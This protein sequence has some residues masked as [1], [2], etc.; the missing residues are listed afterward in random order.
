M[1]GWPA[2][3]AFQNWTPSGA[4]LA[5]WRH[6]LAPPID[7][8]GVLR[9]EPG[10]G[11]GVGVKSGVLVIMTKTSTVIVTKMSVNLQDEY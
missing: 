1:V 5:G 6:P 2:Q 3:H 8:G 11:I 7:K 10:V 9:V 4:S